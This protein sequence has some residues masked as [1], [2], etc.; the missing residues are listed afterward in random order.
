MRSDWAF[1]RYSIKGPGSEVRFRNFFV[2]ECAEHGISMATVMEWVGH[3]EMKMVMYYYSLRDQSARDAMRKLTSDPTESGRTPRS[4]RRHVE[5]RA[6]RTARRRTSANALEHLGS[7][8]E[9]TAFP[10]RKRKITER[11]GFEPPV[12]V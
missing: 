5:R 12:P 7:E 8:H 3:D 9:E 1:G 11:G 10:S 6:G 2:C 4:S